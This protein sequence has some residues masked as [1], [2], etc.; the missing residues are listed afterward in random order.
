MI[1][2][3]SLNNI[4]EQHDR[5]RA[6][7]RDGYKAGKLNRVEE[8]LKATSNARTLRGLSRFDK[9]RDIKK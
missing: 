9:D 3:K 4:S 6:L 1:R 5:C 8:I 7:N 2:K